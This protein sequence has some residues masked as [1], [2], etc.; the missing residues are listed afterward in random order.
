M[1]LP[2]RDHLEA[3]LLREGRQDLARECVTVIPTLAK[4][5]LLGFEGLFE[6]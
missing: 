1:L 5:D 6:H 3:M 2:L 4:L